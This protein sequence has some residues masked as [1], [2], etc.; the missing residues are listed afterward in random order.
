MALSRPWA[1]KIL[2]RTEVISGHLD[3]AKAELK[4]LL[5]MDS[6]LATS[7]LTG[8]ARELFRGLRTEKSTTIADALREASRE[9][10]ELFNQKEEIE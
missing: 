7:L 6:L 9:L 4:S 8:T 1:K 10:H 2:K 5:A 3:T